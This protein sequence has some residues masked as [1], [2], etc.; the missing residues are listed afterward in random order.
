MP[1]PRR[2]RGVIFDL[3]GTLICNHP[4]P[5]DNRERRQCEA[6]GAL[7]AAVVGYA[8]PKAL[9]DRLVA[10]RIEDGQLAGRDLIERPAR[11]TIAQAFREQGIAVS[12][13]LID[14]AERVL[15]EPDRHSRELY[16]G[17]RELLEMLRTRGLRIGLISNWSS[18]YIVTHIASSLGIQDY[19]EPLVSSAA[20]GRI[21]PHPAIFQHVLDAWHLGPQDV[22]MVGD[23]LSTDI[24]GAAAVGMRSILVEIEPNP[25]NGT[26][27]AGV[28]P[29]YRVKHLSEIALLLG[30]AP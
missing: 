11:D 13:G 18:H 19:F 6:I 14:R 22:A 3:G 1:E 25:A 9:A 5:E 7:V 10:L 28:Q 21:K 29:T 20:F 30:L 2:V 12:D 23:T 16:S 26:V 15:F 8:S 24:A 4:H 27:V 17:A